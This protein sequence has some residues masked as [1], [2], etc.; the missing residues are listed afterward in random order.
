[1]LKFLKRFFVI[2]I[3]PIIL[4]GCFPSDDGK[5]NNPVTP[6]SNIT[7]GDKPTDLPTNVNTAANTSDAG[8]DSMFNLLINRVKK[9][10][11]IETAKDY[12]AIDFASLRAG[13][14]AAV[15]NAPSHVKANTGFIVA[16]IMSINSSA[17]LQKIVDSLDKYIDNVDTYYNEDP[18]LAKKGSSSLAKKSSLSAGLLSRT[19][20]KKGILLTGQA[21]V[22]ET[23]KVLLAQT[24]KPSFPRFLTLSY[25]QNAIESDLIPKF[26]EVIASTQRLR[27]LSAM[28]L[29]VTVD[30]EESEIDVGDI[31]MLEG[32][33]RTARAGFTMLLIY[34]A[35][36]YTPDGSKDMR[37][38]DSVIAEYNNLN[39]S[40]GALSISLK[41]D[42]LY[43]TYNNDMST[44]LKYLY[45]VYSYNYGRSNFL[46]IRKNYHTAVYEDLKAIPGLMKS[47][48][49][50]INNEGDNQ[51]NDLF[52]AVDI[53]NLTKD[54]SEFSQELIEEG[55][56][57][58]FAKKFESPESL[59]D[60][61]SLLLTQP[62]TFDETIDGKKISLTVDLS[63]FFTN[64]ASSL[65]DYWPKYRIPTG[66]ERL[67]RLGYV[68]DTYSYTYTQKT[69]SFYPEDYT[70]VNVSIPATMIDSTH[71][72]TYGSK[73]Y[74]LKSPLKAS[75][76]TDSIT[77][78]QPI[79]YIDN[80]NQPIDLYSSLYNGD[81]TT[82]TLTKVFPYFNDYTMRGIFPSMTTRQNWIDFFS[83]FID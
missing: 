53:N 58:T 54:M 63:K 12:Y 28:N 69:F 67:I 55:L 59:M 83:V 78:I 51:D 57:S 72:T 22:A 46:S 31:M 9:L 64:P 8:I 47:G 2:S 81:F 60:F 74:Y 24:A 7:G 20:A 17:N 21:L 26:N 30:G 15:T 34:D 33:V 71:T 23:P 75:V 32:A 76:T 73:T 38:M 11:S 35:D 66:N 13:F 25:I 70:S 27:N 45:D 61:I 18:M 77:T 36:I 68:V 1:M 49:V 16:S 80:N 82:E 29:A 62:Y 42:T 6:P 3:T 48:I 52:K 65:R 79:Q 19:L 14:G 44:E 39:I 56:S 37:W 4:F 5:D 43:R 41:N 50:S 10:D 40:Y